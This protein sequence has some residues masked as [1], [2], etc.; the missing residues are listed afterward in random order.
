[1]RYPKIANWLVFRRIAPNQWEVK[2]Y[3]LEET[4]T[5][6]N[7]LARFARKLDGHVNPYAIDPTLDK[8][9]VD[10]MLQILDENEML[11]YSSRIAVSAGTVYR[12]LWIPKGS[13]FSRILAFANHMLL[14][15]LWLPVFISGILLLWNRAPIL[16][17]DHMFLGSLAGVMLGMLFHELAHGCAC[18]SYGGRVFELGVMLHHF[19]PGAY[20][21]LSAEAIKNRMKRVQIDAAGIEA[22]LMLAG[23]LFLAALQ[24]PAWGGAFVCGAVTNIL[25]AALNLTLIEGFDGAAILSE[26]LGA[27]DLIADAKSIVW[28]RQKRRRWRKKGRLDNGMLAACYLITGVQIALPLLLLV[29]AAE[30]IL[31]LL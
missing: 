8:E 21:L 3:L 28:K 17:R 7:G 22:N 16:G 23:L 11:R 10:E 15:Y 4:C 6:G 26:L 9:D 24:F 25:M 20:V 18:L 31:W 19:L 29:N 2:D 13:G 27:E 12:T 5:I 30:V 1:M 14:K